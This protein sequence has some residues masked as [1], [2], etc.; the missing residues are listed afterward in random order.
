MALRFLEKQFDDVVVEGLGG[1]SVPLTDQLTSLDVL[2][3]CKL[4]T[5]VV[6]ENKVGAINHALLTLN[7]L[8]ERKIPIAGFVMNHKDVS[9]KSLI[10][11]DNPKIIETFSGCKCLGDITLNK[12]LVFKSQEI[13]GFI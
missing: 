4:Q 12:K 8:A 5:I 11:E 13:A 7:A 3:R 2:E 10:L 9:V 1:I 6:V